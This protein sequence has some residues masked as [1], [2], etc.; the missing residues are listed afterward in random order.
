MESGYTNIIGKKWVI[1]FLIYYP[2]IY[3]KI[4]RKIEILYIENINVNNLNTFFVLFRCIRFENN[5]II[6]NIWNM[7]ESDIALDCYIY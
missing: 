3:F 4:D 6:E 7:N 2:D 5:I 1:R